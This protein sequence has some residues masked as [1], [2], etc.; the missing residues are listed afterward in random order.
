MHQWLSTFSARVGCLDAAT[1]HVPTGRLLPRPGDASEVAGPFLT[2]ITPTSDF[3]SST[4]CP[5]SPINSAILLEPSVLSSPPDLHFPHK[6]RHTLPASQNTRYPT[7][8]PQIPPN[9]PQ[10]AETSPTLLYKTRPPPTI[11]C[12]GAKLAAPTA[13]PRAHARRWTN[14]R[15]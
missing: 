3:A 10:T 7:S 8:V 11:G 5:V 9:A 14:H 12:P 2:D 4:F 15:R 1:G 13:M 6:L